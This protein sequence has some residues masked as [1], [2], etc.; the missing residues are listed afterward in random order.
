MRSVSAIVLDK[1][2]NKPLCST[3]FPENGAIYEIMWKYMVEPD[4]PQMTI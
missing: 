4:M 3:P 2:N 1:I